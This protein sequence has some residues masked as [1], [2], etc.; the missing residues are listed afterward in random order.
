MENDT[1]NI[2]AE[3]TANIDK[4]IAT[5]II[6]QAEKSLKY[7]IEVADKTTA[8]SITLLLILLPATSTIVGFL[9]NALK[10][11]KGLLTAET[12]LLMY[13]LLVCIISIIFVVKLMLPRNTM[14][15][16][17]DPKQLIIDELLQRVEY[18]SEQKL[19]A[20]KINEI[21]NFQHKITYN[22]KQNNARI[23]RFKY[24]L[25]Y[26]GLTAIMGLLTYISI[27]YLL[28]VHLL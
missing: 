9:V 15:P 11:N 22:R 14:A 2:S 16:G 12:L 6:E 8:K 4:D 18:T 3:N 10:Q 5:Y 19:L 25:I 21:K 24:I 27:V 17:R 20:Y 28:A 23:L 26:T 13:F 7:S 1:W